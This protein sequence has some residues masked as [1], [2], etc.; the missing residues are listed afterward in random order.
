[1]LHW[2]A[3]ALFT[4]H[5]TPDYEVA[6]SC[7]GCRVFGHY[8]SRKSKCGDADSHSPSSDCVP[9]C[10]I[11][12]TPLRATLSD[13]EPKITRFYR[14]LAELGYIH[15]ILD[16]CGSTVPMRIYAELWLGLGNLLDGTPNPA[17][18][19]RYT[20]HGSI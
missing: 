7:L 20:S 6:R 4:T 10:A 9:P 12:L 15:D 17:I 16:D 1:M 8:P 5:V 13:V 11:V 14:L 19:P 2:C 18:L 3:N